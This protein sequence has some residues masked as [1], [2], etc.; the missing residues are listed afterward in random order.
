MKVDI[1]V[2]VPDS[3][4]EHI[5]I[6][7]RDAFLRD[8]KILKPQ[9]VVY[10]GDQLDCGGVF[11]VHQR[12]YTKELAESFSEDVAATNKFFDL[13]SAIVPNAETH[14]LEGNHEQHIARWASRE[15]QSRKD[16]DLVMSKMGPQ[17]VLRLKERGIKYYESHE[18]HHGL[19][20]PGTIRLGKCYFTHGVSAAK[21]AADVHLSTFGD[22]VIFGHV[23]RAMSVVSRSVTKHAFIAACPGTLAKLQPSYAHTR[24]TTWSHGYGLRLIN[25]R[26]GRFSYFNIPIFKGE[27]MLMDV[28][29]LG[30]RRAA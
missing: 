2:I 19:A 25:P 6:P 28:T 24:P 20:V 9:R 30:R 1:E 10:L 4:G 15:F 29:A 8:L 26:T 5:D 14:M 22:N 16:A 21:A 11:S 23:H 18:M 12:S 17:A 13:V 27:S 3:H 7:A